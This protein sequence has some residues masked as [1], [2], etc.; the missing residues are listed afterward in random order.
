MYDHQKIEKKWQE[1]W[2]KGKTFSPQMARAEKPFYNLMMFPYPSGEGLH[3]GHTY[4]FGGADAYGRYKRLQGYQVFEPMG[5][6][7]FGIHSENFAIKKGLHPTELIAKTTAYFREKQMKRYGGMW[8]WSRQVDTTRPEY[9]R[10]TQWLFVQLFKAG[11]AERKKQLLNWCPSC[12]TVLS[13]EQVEAKEGQNVCERCKT[14]VERKETEQWFF[15]ITD[16]ADRLLDYHGTKWPQTTRQM[17][18]NWIGKST[19]AR[20]AF[21]VKGS[22]EKIEVFTTRPDTLFGVTFLVL[23]PEH[24]LA[25]EWKKTGEKKAEIT[26]YLTAVANKTEVDREAAKEKTGVFSGFWAINPVNGK[27]VPVWIADYVLPGY[28]TGAIMGVPAHDQRDWAFAKKFGLEILP[29]IES[30][31]A[32]DYEKESWEGE[33]RLINSG[34]WTGWRMTGEIEKVFAWL[35]KKGLGKRETQFKLRDWC[36]SRQRYWGPPIP[37]VYCEMCAKQGKS[38][39]TTNEAQEWEKKRK[40]SKERLS[41]L[42]KELAGWYPVAETD[43]PVELPYLSDYQPKGE[44]KSPL[45]GVKKFVET[46]CPECGKPARR[47]TDVSD[48]F[49]DSAWYFLRY[50]STEFNDRPFDRERTEK[51]LPV[52]MYIGGNEH[53]CLHLLYTRFVTMALHDLGYLGFEEP[54]ERFFAHGL[55]IKDGAKMSKSRGN[56]INPE[57]YIEGYGADALRMYL[58]FLGPI[59]QGGDFR[60]AG[61]K[62]TE[63]FLRRF[64]RLAVLAVDRQGEIAPELEKKLHRTIKKMGGDFGKLHFNTAIAALMELVNV[65]QDNEKGANRELVGTVARLVAPVMPH[66]AEELWEMAGGKFSVLD[67]G[68][69]EFSEKKLEEAEVMVAVQINGKLRGELKLSAEQAKFAGEKETAAVLA[70]MKQQEKLKGYLEGKEIKKAVFVP[71][72]LISL[73]TN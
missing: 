23:A 53:A 12:K 64:Y 19:G 8:D 24:R 16:Y 28:G 45:A 6:D 71:G 14:V 30:V 25:K 9:Y 55:I 1:R 49:L 60:D 51:W 36:I 3:V 15:K 72:R 59:K 5:F 7:A 34:E 2:E 39:W 61:I 29:V 26:A 18:M 68:W 40:I 73:V 65:W 11:L 54:F 50:P 13:D 22:G 35:E 10:W 47:E 42:K 63:R 69:P 44:G 58:L 43:L 21:E 57:K 31:P 4:A 56:V 46:S 20:L 41:L 17:Q 33:G 37:M 62:G 52:Q 66:L 38:W 48:T 70:L 32:I 27:K 67:S